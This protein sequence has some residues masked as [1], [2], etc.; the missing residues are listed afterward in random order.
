MF[1]AECSK[2]RPSLVGSGTDFEYSVQIGRD[3]VSLIIDSELSS[4]D[5]RLRG[6]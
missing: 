4:E 3:S 2:C 5:S 1:A 6:V